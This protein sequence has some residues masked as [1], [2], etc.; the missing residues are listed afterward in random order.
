MVPSTIEQDK[1]LYIEKEF[2]KHSERSSR[3]RAKILEKK[4]QARDF[5]QVM[6]DRFRELPKWVRYSVAIPIIVV[7]TILFLYIILGLIKIKYEDA[8]KLAVC[9]ALFVCYWALLKWVFII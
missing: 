7:M 6:T 9:I 1:E 8:I 2:F 5:G 4:Q 3:V